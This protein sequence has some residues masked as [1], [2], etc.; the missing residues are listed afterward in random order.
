MSHSCKTP[1][2]ERICYSKFEFCA[3][4][5]KPLKNCGYPDCTNQCYVK[6]CKTHCKNTIQCEYVKL[7]GER[8]QKTTKKPLCAAHSQKTR[9]YVVQY[10][11]AQRAGI[12]KTESIPEQP[13]SKAISATGN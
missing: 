11:R 5:R 10:K 12:K 3:D 2:C 9:D 4:C 1:N 7:N 6:Y 8:C 13:V